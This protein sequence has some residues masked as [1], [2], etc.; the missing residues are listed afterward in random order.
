MNERKNSVLVVIIQLPPS[1]EPPLVD[2]VEYTK[3]FIRYGCLIFN[4]KS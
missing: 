3:V 1:S 4:I 2:V